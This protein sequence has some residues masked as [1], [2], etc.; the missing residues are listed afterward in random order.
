V[1]VSA[2]S[3]K[4]LLTT[5]GVLTALVLVAVASRGSTPS[6]D[7]RVRGPGD[8]LLDIAFT[9]YIAALFAGALL[10]VYL[11]VLRR[12]VQVQA[13]RARR[14][15]LLELV[16]TM[17]ALVL[18]GTLL[19]K[20][21]LRWELVPATP[22]DE[23]LIPGLGTGT[24]P[25]TTSAETVTYE[26]GFAWLPAL[27]TAGLIVLALVAWWLAGRARKRARGELRRDLATA[28][29][30]AVDESLDDLRAEPDPRRAVIAAYARLERVRGCPAGRPRLR[31]ST[32]RGCLPSSTSASGPRGRSPTS[33]KGL[34]SRSMRSGP[35]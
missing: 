14:R 9:L 27:V 29:A 30:R 19:A 35:R 13:G 8:T 16:L 10:F 20:R 11:L 24:L 4:A 5:L 32:S 2:R 28:V 25:L 34:S 23:G 12:H 26:P 1:E 22:P 33:S 17:F 3:R 7:E 18:I 6:G 15:S 21:M 31:S